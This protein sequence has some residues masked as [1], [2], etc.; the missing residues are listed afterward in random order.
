VIHD[1]FI[2][3]HLLVAVITAGF[4][5][6]KYLVFYI[7]GVLLQGFVALCR[8]KFKTKNLNFFQDVVRYQQ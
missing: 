5:I 3:A 6:I 1:N 2:A 4:F 7:Q 8:V